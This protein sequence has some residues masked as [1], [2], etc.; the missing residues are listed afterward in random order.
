MVLEGEG[1]GLGFWGTQGRLSCQ[2]LL[3]YSSPCAAILAV[4]LT[5]WSGRQEPARIRL[6]TTGHDRGLGSY[7]GQRGWL[8][9]PRG[10][11]SD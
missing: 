1:Q 5:S 6:S 3:E 4:V 8:C 11:F 9:M 7:A 10:A 2:C